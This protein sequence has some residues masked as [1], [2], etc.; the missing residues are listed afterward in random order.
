MSKI[1]VEEIGPSALMVGVLLGIKFLL[2]PNWLK[3]WNFLELIILGVFL[4]ILAH[5]T[6]W[7]L[8]T[9]QQE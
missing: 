9:Y 8:L 7:M 1:R 3:N 5:L 4:G 6:A 2:D